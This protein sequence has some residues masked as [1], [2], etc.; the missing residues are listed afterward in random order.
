MVVFLSPHDIVLLDSGEMF[1]HGLGALSGQKDI[2]DRDER[3]L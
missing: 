1:V 3:M 2:C